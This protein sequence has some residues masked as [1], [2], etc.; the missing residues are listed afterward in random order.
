MKPA[1]IIEEELHPIRLLYFLPLVTLKYVN[2]Y[3]C[4]IK[5]Q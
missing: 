5:G 1:Q 3:L 2:A 4:T